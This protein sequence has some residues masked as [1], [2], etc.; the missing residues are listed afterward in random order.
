MLHQIPGSMRRADQSFGKSGA[1][2]WRVGKEGQ[3][4]P[5]CDLASFVLELFLTLG[6]RA[7]QRARRR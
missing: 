6:V 5:L 3:V 7:V 2:V 4:I 1:V